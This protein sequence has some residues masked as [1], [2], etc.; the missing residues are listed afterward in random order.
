MHPYVY[1]AA[2]P[3]LEASKKHNIVVTSYGGLTPIVREKGGPVDPVVAAIRARLQKDTGKDVTEGQVLGLWLRALGVPEITYVGE[4]YNN[5]VSSPLHCSSTFRTSS[6]AE[7]IKE[8][9]ETQFLPD[10]TPE[11]VQ[12]IKDAG[13]QVHS[14]IFVRVFLHCDF[15][16]V[17]DEIHHPGS[18]SSWTSEA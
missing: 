9:L 13:S 11:E 3:I 7:R 12:S 10:L 1:K 15:E 6:K 17:S 5:R 18:A 8:Y 16:A 14:R 4:S 2:A